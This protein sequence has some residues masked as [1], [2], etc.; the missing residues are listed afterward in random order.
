MLTKNFQF[1]CLGF[2]I[3]HRNSS[4]TDSGR[5]ISAFYSLPI[6][7][8]RILNEHTLFSSSSWH[9]WE[10]L[11]T[12]GRMTNRFPV[13]TTNPKKSSLWDGWG[14]DFLQFITNPNFINSHAHGWGTTQR[15][16]WILD[17]LRNRFCKIFATDSW[18]RTRGHDECVHKMTNIIHNY[19]FVKPSIIHNIA[20]CIKIFDAS[21]QGCWGVY[22]KDNMLVRTNVCLFVSIC[23]LFRSPDAQIR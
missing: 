5:R 7:D 2:P 20:L 21:L 16:E 22:N 14:D 19:R 3:H 17:E 4:K 8:E 11:Q 9:N 1:Q 23:F 18:Q 15:R 12:W 10:I 6:S 13:S